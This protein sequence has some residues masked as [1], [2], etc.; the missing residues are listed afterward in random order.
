MQFDSHSTAHIVEQV[1]RRYW[2]HPDT[3]ESRLERT[4]A[5]EVADTLT[6]ILI[7]SAGLNKTGVGD[8]NPSDLF[9]VLQSYQKEETACIGVLTGYGVCQLW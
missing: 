7:V 1:N 2:P 4:F 9:G 8:K 3:S 5:F 6:P